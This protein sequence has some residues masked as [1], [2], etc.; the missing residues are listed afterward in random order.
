MSVT[1][2]EMKFSQLARHATWMIPTYRERIRRF[3]DGLNYSLGILMTRERVLGASFEEVVD[4][5]RDIETVRRIEREEREAK[6]P[7]GSGSFSGAPSRGQFQRGRGRSFRPPQP[8]RPEYSRTSSDCGHQGFQQG[9]SLLNALPAQSSSYA[10]LVQG[11]SVPSASAGHS[12][13]E[14]IRRFV[15]GL[16]YSLRILMTRERVLGAS[17]EEVVDIARDIEI[18][19]CREREEREAKR[20]RGSGSFGGAPSRGQ[21]QCGRGR[22]FRPPQPARPEYSRTSSDRGH[23]GFQQGQSSLNALPAQSSSYA[24][25]VQGSSVPSASAG[26]SGARGSLQFPSPVPGSCYECREFGHIKR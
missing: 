25:S 12:D 1:R 20:P 8:A 4:I 19:R 14:R 18:V 23:Q 11:S 26:H 6:R 3:V 24:P 22:S 16:N 17:F 9:Q 7:R 21:F 15:D 13:R 2:Y 10:P 5:T